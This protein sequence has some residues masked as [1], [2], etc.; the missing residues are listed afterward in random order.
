VPQVV[1]ARPPIM[2]PR[3]VLHADDL[4]MNRAVSEGILRGFR[5]G[6]LTS[7]S[8]LANAPDADRALQRWKELTAEH[9]AGG[10]PSATVRIQ[11]GD[12]GRP[13]DLGVHLNLTQGRPLTDSRYPTELLD[14]EGRFPGIFG[15]FARLQ[16]YGTRFHAA[17]Q[18]E[19]EQQVQVV[20][21]HGL[22]PTHLNGHQYIEMLPAV[23]Q[24]LPRLLDRFGIQVVRVA[25]EPSLWRTTVLRAQP[26]KWPMARLKRAF[27]GRFLARIDVLGVAHPDAFFGTIHAGSVDLPLLRQFLKKG[28]RNQLRRTI[29][30]GAGIPVCRSTKSGTVEV[31]LHPGEAAE[32]E[33]AQDQT[34]GWHDPLAAARPNELRMLL[35]AELPTLLQSAGWRLGRLATV[36]K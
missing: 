35:S 11:L 5:E 8:L 34:A 31:G 22:R 10:L 21:D 23:T 2:S 16:R 25:L 7:T 3:L 1:F 18:A 14:V 6:L 33:S 27:A 13:F 32:G 28:V 17:V 30:G 26:W 24:L 9:F 29:A 19:L 4:G 36:G 12:A 20:C 15:L